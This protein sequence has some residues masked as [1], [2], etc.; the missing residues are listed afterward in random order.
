MIIG[1]IFAAGKGTRLQPLTFETPKPLLKINETES[2]LTFN[3]K[4]LV[5]MV[6]SFVIVIN[7][8]GDQIRDS[9]G[10]SFMGKRVT[11]VEQISPKGGTLDAFRAAI[12]GQKIDSKGI[13]QTDNFINTNYLVSNADDIFGPKIYES[14]AHSL[15]E[16]SELGYIVGSILEDKEKLKSFGVLEKDENNMLMQMHEKPQ[17]FISNLVNIGLYYFPSNSLEFITPIKTLP[18]DQEDFIT[19]NLVLPYAIKYGIKVIP[20]KDVW[21]A[22]TNVSDYENV[23]QFFIDNADKK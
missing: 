11:Y 21:L 15:L 16:N 10:D 2:L 5:T 22:V 14:L 4:N 17:H 9:I 3:M 13:K 7:Y 8:L 23:K 6:D 1:V 19:T 18:D 12:Y 20:A